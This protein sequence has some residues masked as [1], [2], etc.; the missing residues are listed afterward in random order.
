MGRLPLLIALLFLCSAVFSE[1]L[2]GENGG[3]LLILCEGQTE[4]FV[5]P[6]S[7]GAQAVLLDENYQ[8]EFAAPQ[9]GPYSVQ[10][11]REVKTAMVGRAWEKAGL[12]E[13]EGIRL[14]I[15]V[16]ALLGA[17]A[18]ILAVRF[19]YFSL[20]GKVR[21]TKSVSNG[22]AA[23]EVYSGSALCDVEIEDG[24]LEGGKLLVPKIGAWKTWRFSYEA[25]GGAC[26][27]G[28][29]A[30]CDGRRISEDARIFADGKEIDLKNGK[31]E[32]GNLESGVKRRL[33]KADEAL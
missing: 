13:G 16:V 4:V 8:A 11:G 24:Q 20:V 29:C 1:F 18:L 5:S 33:L 23:L 26:K 6:P 3:R 30:K 12:V 9:S 15:A 22:R 27:A 21:F 14:E 2:V 28:L 31:I 25:E 10:C 17:L 32:G 7:G 19:L